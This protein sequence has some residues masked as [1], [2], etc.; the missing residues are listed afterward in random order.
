MGTGSPAEPLQ[1]ILPFVVGWLLLPV[2]G[3]RRR[4]SVHFASSAPAGAG[5][6][7]SLL[8]PPSGSLSLAPGFGPGIFRRITARAPDLVAGE[9][10]DPYLLRWHVARWRGWQLALHLILR[11]DDARALH[12]HR[13]DN[14]SLI[15][16]GSYLEVLSHAWERPYRARKRLAWR[17]WRFWRIYLRRAETPHRL[18]LPGGY[19]VWT[20]WL[21][22]PPR[23]EWGFWCSR[24][25]R[26][27]RA[28]REYTAEQ[29][30][31]ASQ[32]AGRS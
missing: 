25:C 16:Q 24:G 1:K 32:R 13:A 30:R 8:A 20:L 22:G 3:K 7:S 29:G 6:A 11:S 10:S 18:V 9:A 5:P 12:D 17:P 2:S 19:P 4:M 26:G 27:W 23:R 15:L 28:W 14:A 31:R 21:R